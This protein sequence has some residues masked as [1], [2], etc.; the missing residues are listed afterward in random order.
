[1]DS[2][3]NLPP[4]SALCQAT[5]PVPRDLRFYCKVFSRVT[6]QSQVLRLLKVKTWDIGIVLYLRFQ[7][8]QSTVH[9]VMKKVD[10]EI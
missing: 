4:L 9:F 2:T 6:L 3:P 5:K 10:Q 7:L 8:K 1:M